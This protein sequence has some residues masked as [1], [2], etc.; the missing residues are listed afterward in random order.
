LEVHILAFDTFHLKVLTEYINILAK[1][2]FN[3]K[4]NAD[5]ILISQTLDMS[6]RTGLYLPGLESLT[7][8][9][10]W[11]YLKFSAKILKDNYPDLLHLGNINRLQELLTDIIDIDWKE[12]LNTAQVTR[13]DVTR[14]FICTHPIDDYIL[15]LFCIRNPN[16]I[17]SPYLPNGVTFHK[18]CQSYTSNERIIFYDKS[19]ELRSSRNGNKKFLNHIFDPNVLKTNFKNVLRSEINLR[20]SSRISKALKISKPCRLIDVLSSAAN[21][22]LDLFLKI[23]GNHIISVTDRFFKPDTFLKE[24][25]SLGMDVIIEQCNRNIHAVEKRIGIKTRG[26]PV[27]MLRQVRRR[28]EELE[29]SDKL[30]LGYGI[31]LLDQLQNFL[32]SDNLQNAENKVCDGNS[33]KTNGPEDIISKYL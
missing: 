6:K 3:V 4:Q 27:L 25:K 29:L 24:M 32:A 28:I 19:T 9:S 7:V 20:T 8:G 30:G 10:M 2:Y 17:S 31:N 21:P 11:T 1:R 18:I 22:L 5:G 23:R 15:A 33:N 14:N 16:Y 12:F 26:R 13:C